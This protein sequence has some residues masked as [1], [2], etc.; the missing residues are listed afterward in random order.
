VTKCPQFTNMDRCTTMASAASSSSSN[1]DTVR[2][3]SA[4]VTAFTTTT[5]AGT[6]SG[7][8]CRQL[9]C[10]TF[11]SCGTCPYD[12]KCVFLHDLAVA[13]SPV[14]IEKRRKS[15]EDQVVDAFF[16]PTMQ[17][18]AVGRHRD[19]N[20]MLLPNI[21]QAYVVGNP[22]VAYNEAA[23]ALARAI[24]TSAAENKK[25]NNPSTISDVSSSTTTTVISKKKKQQLKLQQLKQQKQHQQ[26]LQLL[27][28]QQH[29]QSHTQTPASVAGGINDLAVY[30]MWQHFLDFCKTD[31]L[32][33]V[34]VPRAVSQGKGSS[35]DP[36]VVK[37]VYTG[38]KRLPVFVQLSQDR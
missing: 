19:N 16:W 35:M 36:Y 21:Y 8:K 14:F 18:E 32:S 15:K 11:I 1:I 28:Q 37:N 12:T 20:N 38:R 26:Q 17:K 10:R 33:V 13:S 4:A 23:A 30:S 2:T 6:S 3:G 24:E 34:T 7:G 29:L 5:A 22:R 27:L 9:P 31:E 25:S